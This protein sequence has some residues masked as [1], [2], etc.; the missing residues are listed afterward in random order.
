MSIRIPTLK[1]YREHDGLHYRNLWL[2]I[3]DA[4][5]CPGCGRTKYQIMRWAKRF[6]NSPMAFMGWVAALHRH[7]D[8]SV[9]LYRNRPGRFSPTVIC[10]QCNSADGAVKR[11]LKL[12]ATF[13]FAP[14]EIRMFVRATPHSPHSIDFDVALAIYTSIIAA[15]GAIPPPL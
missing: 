7:H 14:T 6:P 12:P 13:S 8:H 5:A 9:G 11:R 15:S 4:W 1:E 3:D 10:D 2:K